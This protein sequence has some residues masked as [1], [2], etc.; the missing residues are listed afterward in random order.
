M[1]FAVSDAK[2]TLKGGDMMAEEQCE[3]LGF[4]RS[5]GCAL[6]LVD[7]KI[8]GSRNNMY[9]NEIPCYPGTVHAVER[10]KDLKRRKEFEE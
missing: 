9:L 6:Y 5:C 1:D 8:K 4:C 10:R 2:C 7:S 3:F